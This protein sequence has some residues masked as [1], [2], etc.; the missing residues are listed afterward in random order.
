M[1]KCDILD[2]NFTKA[3]DLIKS[4]FVCAI[5][6]EL[7]EN[8]KSFSEISK[9]FSY[10]TN[11]SLSRTL[12]KL[13]D[14]RIIIKDDKSYCLSESGIELRTIIVSLGDW[15]EKSFDD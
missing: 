15:Y 14:V 8:E 6:V 9:E 5:I 4:R 3:I 7:S 12:K 1:E 10:L 11:A 2:C 13:C